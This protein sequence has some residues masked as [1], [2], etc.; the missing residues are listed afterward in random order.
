MRVAVAQMLSTS[1]PVENLHIVRSFT[2]RAAKRN[3]RLVVFPEAAMANFSRSS[4]AVAE[5]L[6]GPW[7]TGIR[8]I[9]KEFSI[10]IVAGMFTTTHTDRCRNTI[11]VVG[12]GIDAHYHKIHLYDAFGY[13]ES[14]YFTPGS[15]AVTVTF[16]RTKLGLATCYDIRFPELFKYLALN[17]AEIMVVPSSWAAGPGKVSQW[18]SLVVSRA[19]DSTSFV[20]ACGQADPPSAGKRIRPGSPTGV[21][22]SLVVGPDGRVLAEAGPDPG[23]MVVDLDLTEIDRTRKQVP[24]LR[25]T[26]FRFDLPS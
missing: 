14:D 2:E 3:A 8:T 7:A 22:H 10:T 1:D 5:P 20:V 11:L 17:G 24:V 19:L 12:R 23:L 13:K 26:F 25:D 9:A 18:R 4:C 6:D 16:G 15:E 21:G